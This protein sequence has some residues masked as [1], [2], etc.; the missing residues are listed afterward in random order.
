MSPLKLESSNFKPKSKCHSDVAG[1][2]CNSGSE[3]A[4]VSDCTEDQHCNIRLAREY[5]G[6]FWLLFCLL[7]YV[8][9]LMKLKFVWTAN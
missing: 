5:L 7:S 9:R 3:F 1:G 8:L 2:R 6:P 4:T